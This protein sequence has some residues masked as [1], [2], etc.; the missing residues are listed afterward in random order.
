MPE[1]NS[2]LQIDAYEGEGPSGRVHPCA[3]GPT[4]A[5]CKKRPD[6]NDICPMHLTGWSKENDICSRCGL[7][8]HGREYLSPNQIWERIITG[9]VR[10]VKDIDT[11]HPCAFPGCTDL[12]RGE[13]CDKCRTTIAN[14][15]IMWRKAY[16]TEAPAA[17]YLQ[18]KLGHGQK[19][20]GL[21]D[22]RKRKHTPR[23][24]TAPT[25]DGKPCQTCGKTLR[26]EKNK[27][28]VSCCLGASKRQLK[29]RKAK[30]FDPA[31]LLLGAGKRRSG[32]SIVLT[33]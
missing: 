2:A 4:A 10:I 15:K 23:S 22:L 26:Y 3:N 12:T 5:P 32:P 31:H 14:R 8:P 9:R 19:L 6:S 30:D 24:R 13:Y 17:F 18:A 27:G 25:F 1:I 11:P 33:D 20:K 21:D 28:C 7:L 29:K 16:G